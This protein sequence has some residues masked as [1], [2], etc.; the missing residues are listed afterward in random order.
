MVARER[1]HR[2]RHARRDRPRPAR[3]RRASMATSV[4]VPMARPMSAAASAGASLIPSPTKAIVPWASRS[5]SSLR[6]CRGQHLGGDVVDAR[7]A[8]DGLGRCAVVAGDH[9]GLRGPARAARRWRRGVVGFDG[10]STAMTAPGSRRRRH[11]S[12]VLPSSA[13]RCASSARAPSVEADR[14]A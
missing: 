5:A 3:R 4:P 14:R 12:G 10:S 11:N 7:A 8:G 9:R 2:G 6:P 13:S 1:S